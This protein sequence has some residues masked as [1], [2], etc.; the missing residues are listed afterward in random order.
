MWDS[1]VS[2]VMGYRLDGWVSLPGTA[3]GFS[4]LSNI[5]ASSGA[6]PASYSLGTEDSFLRSKAVRTWS[7]PPPSS[8]EVKNGGAVPPF[9]HISLWLDIY[10]IKRKDN[11]TFKKIFYG[12]NSS[13]SLRLDAIDHRYLD[14]RVQLRDCHT[15]NLPDQWCSFLLKVVTQLR[16]VLFLWAPKFRYHTSINKFHFRNIS[17]GTLIRYNFPSEVSE[18]CPN[19]FMPLDLTTEILIV[20][21]FLI[22]PCM[23]HILFIS[24]CL[25]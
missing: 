2:V 17:W 1:L 20:Y 18:L 13:P 7:W 5:Q 4:S 23:L 12:G 19:V 24:S 16:N 9:P 8:A 10:L 22:P 11:F 3:S 25:T 6:H 15:R 14:H 21:E